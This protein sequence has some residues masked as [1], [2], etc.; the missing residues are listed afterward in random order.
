MK[1]NFKPLTKLLS[2]FRKRSKAKPA[3]ALAAKLTV[4]PQAGNS[5]AGKL[6]VAAPPSTALAVS[7]P[8]TPPLIPQEVRRQK[9]EDRIKEFF[10]LL[11]SVF[12]VF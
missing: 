3:V 5:V 7:K 6:P 2:T 1:I 10:C 8:G 12:W 9:S 4:N 11:S